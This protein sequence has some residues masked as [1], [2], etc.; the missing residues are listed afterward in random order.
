MMP[1]GELLIF[2]SVAGLAVAVG[3]VVGMIVATRL[4]RIANP[5]GEPRDPVPEP[6][7]TEELQP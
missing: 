5:L 7:A 2:V 6:R 3:I 4:D 1:V